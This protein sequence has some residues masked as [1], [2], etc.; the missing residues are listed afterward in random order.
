MAIVQLFIVVYIHCVSKKDPDVIHCNVKD[1]QILIVF[2]TNIPDA[3]GHQVTGHVSTSPSVCS[4]TTW[5]NQNTLVR[6]EELPC[7]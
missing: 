4:C 7:M 3:A 2:V 1:D 5:G 6:V